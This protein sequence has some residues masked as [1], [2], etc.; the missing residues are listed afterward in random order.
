MAKKQ[1]AARSFAGSFA[2]KTEFGIFLRN[3][4]TRLMTRPFVARLFMGSLL[5]D[6]LP[7]PTYRSA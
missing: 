4:I 6:P 2:P 5:N 7:L 1:H 3:H